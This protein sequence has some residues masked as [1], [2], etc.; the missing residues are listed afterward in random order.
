[1]EADGE[2]DSK[3]Q[4]VGK[5]SNLIPY[6]EKLYY[7]KFNPLFEFYV[8]SRQKNSCAPGSLMGQPMSWKLD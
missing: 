2:N 6:M 5:T 3:W 8:G 7:I 1:M 4:S